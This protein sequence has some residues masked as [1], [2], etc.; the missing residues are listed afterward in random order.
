[1]RRLPGLLLASLVWLGPLQAESH[2][3]VGEV[4]VFMRENAPEL[5]AKEF[6]LLQQDDQGSVVSFSAIV[7]GGV[8]TFGV[9]PDLRMNHYAFLGRNPN[10]WSIH[11]AR[12]QKRLQLAAAYLW[13]VSAEKLAQEKSIALVEIDRERERALLG[14]SLDSAL[15]Q[16]FRANTEIFSSIRAA[17]VARNKPLAHFDTRDRELGPLFDAATIESSDTVVLG[18]S[19]NTPACTSS[20]CFTL[21]IFA[22]VGERVGFFHIDQP[23]NLPKMTPRNYLAVRP[24]GDGWYL[25]RQ[26]TL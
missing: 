22:S 12:L 14:A 4:A 19:S 6:E 5:D 7:P 24:L 15:I 13:T 20:Q 9:V 25:F 23:G 2:D 11:D 17:I 3:V 18:N 16:H 21:T 1:M 8:E 26:R 10:G